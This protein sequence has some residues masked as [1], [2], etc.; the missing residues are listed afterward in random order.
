MIKKISRR[1]ACKC[2]NLPR[3]SCFYIRRKSD[4][5]EVIH[6]LDQLVEKHAAIGFWNCYHRLRRKGLIW[7]HK[8]V[9]RVYTAMKLNLRRRAK[10]RSLARVKQALYTPESINQ[11]WSID[12]MSDSLWDGRKFRVLNILDDFNREALCIEPDLSLPAHRV[13]RALET[14]EQYR[15]LPS[16]IRIDNG[17][18]FISNKLAEWCDRKKIS[19]A[20]IQPG[21]PTQNAYVERFNGSMRRELLNAYIFR[22]LDEVRLKAEEWM[23]D[24]NN[25]RPHKALGFKTPADLLLEISS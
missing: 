24:Y 7:N 23:Y 19:L 1:Q 5:H 20:F 6:E 25:H 9:Y 16:M 17:P 22:T 13:V 12:F 11:V 10:K 8:R 14:L 15:G 3:S 2:V 4:D 18:E 21:Q